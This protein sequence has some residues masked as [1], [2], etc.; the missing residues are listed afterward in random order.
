LWP[1]AFEI[2]PAWKSFRGSRVSSLSASEEYFCA[3]L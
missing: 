3:S 1:S 2:M